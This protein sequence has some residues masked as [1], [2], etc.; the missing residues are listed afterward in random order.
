MKKYTALILILTIILAAAITGALIFAFKSASR[1]TSV[2]NKNLETVIPEDTLKMGEPIQIVAEKV[3]PGKVSL[4][5]MTGSVNISAFALRVFVNE[6]MGE[7]DFL[8]NDDLVQEGWTY[9]INKITKEEELSVDIA[10]TYINP[11]IYKTDGKLTIGSLTAN[12]IESNLVIDEKE[13][14][15]VDKEGNIYPLVLINAGGA[16]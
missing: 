8:P 15:A 4:T 7:I 3:E 9:P 6:D 1:Q 13:S 16:Q 2:V 14:K 12:N 10:G 5:I 11:D